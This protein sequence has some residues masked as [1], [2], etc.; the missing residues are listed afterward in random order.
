MSPAIICM[1]LGPNANSPTPRSSRGSPPLQ[2]MPPP[3]FPFIPL[4]RN[5]DLATGNILTSHPRG[6]GGETGPLLSTGIVANQAAP[7]Q[8]RHPA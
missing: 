4:D 1:M 3:V 6:G 8:P 2:E 5:P 7:T